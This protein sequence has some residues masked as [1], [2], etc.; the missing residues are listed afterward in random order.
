VNDLTPAAI[1]E[2]PDDDLQ[3]LLGSVAHEY[4]QRVV[5]GGADLLPFAP[6][7]ALSATETLVVAGQLLRAA[8]I[9]SFELASMLNI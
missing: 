9:S 4:A 1:A 5:G 8:E 7:A 6:D 2:L 3:R